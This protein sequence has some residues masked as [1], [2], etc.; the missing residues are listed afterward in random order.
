LSRLEV[1]GKEGVTR[2]AQAFA[3]GKSYRQLDR[4]KRVFF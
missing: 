2:V 4:E 3:G 1:V